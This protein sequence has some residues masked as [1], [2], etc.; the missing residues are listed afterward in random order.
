MCLFVSMFGIYVFGNKAN[1]TCHYE[2]WKTTY[3]LHIITVQNWK[4]MAVTLKNNGR[5]YF[6]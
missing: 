3:L 2:E 5:Y 6:I 4:M 1:I